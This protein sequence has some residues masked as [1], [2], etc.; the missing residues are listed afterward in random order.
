MNERGQNSSE[1]H[2]RWRRR[3]IKGAAVVT[4][5]TAAVGIGEVENIVIDDSIKT[6]ETPANPIEHIAWDG[7]MGSLTIGAVVI[8]L[9]QGRFV[10]T[11][12]MGGDKNM[13][14]KQNQDRK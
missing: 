8:A 14:R 12:F 4:L 11:A 7:L 3:I 5:A 9:L 6:W 2:S 13:G 10:S 1:N